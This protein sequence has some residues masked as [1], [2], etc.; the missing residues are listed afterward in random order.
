MFPGGG[1]PFDEFFARY[2]QGEGQRQPRHRIDITQFLSERAREL[3]N[4]AARRAGETGSGD[5]DTEH[6]LWAMT[7]EE[8]T[9]QLLSR[10]ATLLRARDDE[11]QWDVLAD[12]E[13]NEF[14]VFA[15]PSES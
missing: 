4:A 7:E 3:I 6:L 2:M 1:S 12:P 8:S 9:R 14:C 11:I 15:E 13:G 5:L 10:G